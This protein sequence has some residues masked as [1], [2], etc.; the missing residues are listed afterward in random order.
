MYKV[1]RRTTCLCVYDLFDNLQH[2]LSVL[3]QPVIL[4]H[5]LHLKIVMENTIMP[6]SELSLVCDCVCKGKSICVWVGEIHA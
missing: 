2:I 4:E 6:V 5:F 1:T 3:C